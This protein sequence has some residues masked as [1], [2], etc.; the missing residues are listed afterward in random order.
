[1]FFFLLVSYSTEIMQHIFFDTG[2]GNKCRL[3]KIQDIENE[4]G[5]EIAKALPGLDAFTGCD[6]T[7][8]FMRKG[9]KGPL[10]VLKRHTQY[11]KVFQRLGEEADKL[12][13]ADFSCLER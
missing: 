11:V 6:S 4:L 7:S 1:M 10:T 12:S 8:A 13:D 2:H 5:C 9:K 3:I